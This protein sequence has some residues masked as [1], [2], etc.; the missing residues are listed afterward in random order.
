MWGYS[1]SGNV[2]ID[3]NL[4][5]IKNG[6]DFSY[7]G[8]S[9][10]VTISSGPTVIVD[11]AGNYIFKDLKA[12]SYVLTLNVPPGYAATNGSCRPVMSQPPPAACQ[13]ST[14]LP[15]TITTSNITT[16]ADFGITPS[17]RVEGHVYSD[18]TGGYCSSARNAYQGAD[19]T[20]TNTVTGAL[21]SSPYSTTDV[22]GYYLFPSVFNGSYNLSI[23][24]PA[25]YSVR[26]RNVNGAGWQFNTSNSIL[27]NF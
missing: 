3:F 20:L 1:V 11:A 12:G 4:D 7:T 6:S 2:F 16:G 22:N 9:A 21:V 27:L 23:T 19:L 25:G 18:P 26:G 14:T 8:G 13:T 24:A 10:S 17:N 15:I 5:G